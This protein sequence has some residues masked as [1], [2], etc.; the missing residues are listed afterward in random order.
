[1]R[2]GSTNLRSAIALRID[3]LKGPSKY[4][5]I[6]EVGGWGGQMMMFDD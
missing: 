1:M 2:R 6:K 3:I 4:Y 5:V